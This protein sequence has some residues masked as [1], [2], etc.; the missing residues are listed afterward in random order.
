MSEHLIVITNERAGDDAFYCSVSRLIID[1]N[2][3]TDHGADNVRCKRS[4]VIFIQCITFR[5][6]IGYIEL[7]PEGAAL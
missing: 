5:E 7:F 4:S 1:L 6:S 2:R 3:I